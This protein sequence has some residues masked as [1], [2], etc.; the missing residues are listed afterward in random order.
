MDELCPS[1]LPNVRTLY[2][3]LFVCLFVCCFLSSSRIFHSYTDVTITGEGLQIFSFA[4][5]SWPLSS[6]GSIACL[7]YCD[8]GHSFLMVISEDPW[9]SHLLP[10]VWQWGCHYLF[11]FDLG[12]SRLGFEHPIFRLRGERSEDYITMKYTKLKFHLRIQQSTLLGKIIISK[13]SRDKIMCWIRLIDYFVFY[14]YLQYSSH[15][16]AVVYSKYKIWDNYQWKFFT[17]KHTCICFSNFYLNRPPEFCTMI[18]LA[19]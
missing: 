14:A 18:V 2:I 10:S 19:M 1:N 17:Y 4:R 3:C 12:L 15:V 13:V 7:T 9:H 11:F 8:T 16:A 5:H 6:E